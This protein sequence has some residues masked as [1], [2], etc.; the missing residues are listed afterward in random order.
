MRTG[1]GGG[2]WGC[3][4]YYGL[5]VHIHGHGHIRPWWGL[6]GGLGSNPDMPLNISVT[7]GK[8][9]PLRLHSLSTELGGLKSIYPGGL[10]GGFSEVMLIKRPEQ[11]PDGVVLVL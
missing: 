2:Q 3:G 7:L 1:E 11:A 10:L 4:C 9:A 6:A 5:D 8:L